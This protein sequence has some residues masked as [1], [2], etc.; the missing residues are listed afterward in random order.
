M[1]HQF[2]RIE[3]QSRGA[4]VGL[5][6]SVTR[7]R[8]IGASAAMGVTAVLLPGAV[9]SASG[10]GGDNVSYSCT[11]VIPFLTVEQ[12]ATVGNFIVTA[13]ENSAV[14]GSP[15][16]AYLHQSNDRIRTVLDFEPANLGGPLP[17]SFV[18]QTRNHADGTAERY[19]FTWSLSGTTVRTDYIQNQDVTRSY[20]IPGGFDRL[21]IDY[22]HPPTMT[23]GAYGSYL[24]LWIPC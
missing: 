4:A 9:A 24:D 14:Q 13:A 16:T 10:G 7:R 22:T 8:V 3:N 5:P 18:L 20:S 15:S 23:P 19:D 12:S 11:T 1:S 17:T 21:T 6:L 2:D